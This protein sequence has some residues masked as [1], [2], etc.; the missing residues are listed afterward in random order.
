[1]NDLEHFFFTLD[2]YEVVEVCE[3]EAHTINKIWNDEYSLTEYQDAV[4]PYMDI[5]E[6]EDP[7]Y[8]LELTEITL[9]TECHCYAP[10]SICWECGNSS[11]SL[12]VTTSL[13]AEYKKE[14]YKKSTTYKLKE[15]IKRRPYACSQ[16]DCD[17]ITGVILTR[18]IKSLC[19]HCGAYLLPDM[20][21]CWRCLGWYSLEDYYIS[22]TYFN[23]KKAALTRF[24]NKHSLDIAYD[25]NLTYM[26]ICRNC[27]WYIEGGMASCS[28]CG[29]TPAIPGCSSTYNNFHP[30]IITTKDCVEKEKQSWEM[31]KEELNRR[32]LEPKGNV[33]FD[34]KIRHS[35]IRS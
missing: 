17:P 4:R 29:S 5:G 10:D 2:H 25:I 32:A 14:E 22:D 21:R 12:F 35:T 18:S 6:D 1:M 27:G 9:C 31:F 8:M 19:H 16:L 20:K 7:R 15:S 33:K 3:E 26:F 24:K 34:R 13:N 11:M 30:K 23:S 28:L